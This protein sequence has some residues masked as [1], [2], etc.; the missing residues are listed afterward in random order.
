MMDT[1]LKKTDAELEACLATANE[2]IECWHWEIKDNAEREDWREVNHGAERLTWWRE[3]KDSIL[4][5]M[6]RRVAA[7]LLAENL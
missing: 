1:F 6:A 2:H 3:T 5:E 7:D 4:K